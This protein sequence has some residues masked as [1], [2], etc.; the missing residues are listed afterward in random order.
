MDLQGHF[1]SVRS[2]SI[3]MNI[4]VHKHHHL[5]SLLQDRAI[6]PITE[7]LLARSFSG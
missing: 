5:P 4:Q 6:Y 3:V 2:A 7:V 1:A